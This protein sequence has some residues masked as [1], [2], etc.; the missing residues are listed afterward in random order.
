MLTTLAS[1]DLGT[2]AE[3]T[4]VGMG[5]RGGVGLLWQRLKRKGEPF[6]AYFGHV[7]EVT[8]RRLTAKQRKALRDACR[9][10]ALKSSDDIADALIGSGLHE[11]EAGRI[12]EEVAGPS[13]R[14]APASCRNSLGSPAA[15]AT[16]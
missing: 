2:T 13:T 16:S 9:A 5:L 7:A 4:T 3:A 1:I 12:A 10:G 6:D 15:P 14:R 8:G 11:D